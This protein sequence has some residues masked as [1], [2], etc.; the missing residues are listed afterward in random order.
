LRYNTAAGGATAI[1]TLA[2][3]SI[4]N[5]GAHAPHGS[6]GAGAGA[7]VDRSTRPIDPESPLETPVQ[8]VK[9]VGPRI[10]LTLRKLELFTVE[11][12]LFHFPL[13]YEDRTHFRPL[14]QLRDGET[15]CSCG[16]VIGVGIERTAKRKLLLTKV[17]IQDNTGTA[18]LT[19]FAQPW[20][21]AVFER[22]QGQPISV[23]GTVR[24][25]RMTAAAQFQH[26]EWEELS[27]D[28]GALH[29]NR[30]VP[31]HPLTEG[32]SVKTLRTAIYNALDRYAG[33]APDLLPPELKARLNLVDVTTALFQIHFPDSLASLEAARRRLVFDELFLLQ[34]ALAMRKRTLTTALPGIAF[35]I[36]P[37]HLEELCRSLPFELTAAQRRVI[38]EIAGDMARP[39]PMN[40]LLQGDVGSGKTIVAAAAILTAA[41]NGYQSALMVPTEILA[42]QHYTVMRRLLEPLGLRVHRLVGAVRAKGKRIIKEEL[43]TGMADF[44]VGTHAL[45]QEGIAFRK[46]GLVIIDEQHRFG[47]LQRMALVD[48]AN[49][50]P[51]PVPSDTEATLP[52]DDAPTNDERPTTNGEELP[53]S[54]PGAGSREPGAGSAA[55][56]DV[57]VMTATPIPRT[58]A[59]TVYGDLDVSV[60]DELPP[61]RKPIRTYWRSKV[62]RAQIY[63]GVRKLVGEGKQVY[64]VCPLVEESDKLQA[65]AATELRDHLQNDVFPDLRV[66]LV[67]GQ[68]PSWEKDEVM[69]QFRAREIDV[70]VATVVIEVG[71]DVPNACCMIIEDAERF[72]L[73]QLHQLR[74]RVGRGPDQSFCI[75]LADPKSDDG[76][77]RLEAMVRTCDG[78][79][80][81]E[82]DLK[83]RGPGEF[84]GTKQSGILKLR[85]ANIIGDAKILDVA[86]A[87]AF[88]LVERDPELD[89]PEHR[90]LRE[91]L[92]SHYQSIL[93]ATVG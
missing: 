81:A 59:L 34:T 44:V 70:L 66:G 29:V 79:A 21:K 64:I 47:V 32:L 56:P 71:V 48:K 35:E 15:V 65:R 6:D 92:R 13:R 83:L 69:E 9:G 22:L 82:E 43:A 50:E 57:L 2:Q 52:F 5:Q 88:A 90:R 72:G 85:I 3:P 60:I 18:S 7:G 68:M 17:A 87:E 86:R 89:L 26:P 67:H 27:E 12:L 4:E 53:P 39:T 31:I 62:Q 76:R 93:L 19:F 77:Q 40:R 54:Q 42:E 25:E 80:I 74:G 78:F 38:G 10:A 16:T 73:A 37:E 75:L 28:A 41:R 20:L 63:G 84:Y 45:I 46:L 61:E 30:I 23:Y 11:D 91:H 55:S 51:A 1:D 36:R 58:L 49:A 33:Y 8:F 24:R 14:G